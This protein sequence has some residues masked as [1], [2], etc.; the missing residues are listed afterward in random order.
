MSCARQDPRGIRHSAEKNHFPLSA[1]PWIRLVVICLLTVG[2]AGAQTPYVSAVTNSASLS[3]VVSPGAL[4]SIFGTGLGSSASDTAVVVGG[5]AAVVLFV[6]E[7]R[8]NAQL[9]LELE[10]GVAELS[11][12]SHGMPSA[13][14]K[15][16]V[17]R[18]APALFSVD[19]SGSGQGVFTD[20]GGRLI[21]AGVLPGSIVEAY[22]VG[23]GETTPSAAPVSQQGAPVMR[24]VKLPAVHLGVTRAEV[25]SAILTNGSSGVY[26]VEFVVPA[27]L[28]GNWNVTVSMEGITSSPVTLQVATTEFVSSLRAP[29]SLGKASSGSS[30]STSTEVSGSFTRRTGQAL[31]VTGRGTER[32]VNSELGTTSPIADAA[33]GAVTVAGG[34]GVQFT[35]DATLSASLCG[36]VQTVVGGLYARTFT[37]ANANIYI[38]LGNTGLAQS[39]TSLFAVTYN[40]FRNALIASATSSNDRTAVGTL[41]NSNPLGTRQ[42][43]LTN[44]NARV[45]GF[46]PQAGLKPDGTSCFLSAVG[47]YDGIVTLSTSLNSGGQFYFRTGPAIASSQ[48]DFF[49]SIEHEVDEVLGTSSCAFD[50]ANFSRFHPPDLFRYHSDGSRSFAEG[51]NSSCSGARSTN[52]CFSI[53]GVHMLQQYNNVNDGTDAGDWVRNCSSYLVQ[54]AV[55][56]PDVG[57]VDISASAEIVVLDVI[58]YTLTGLAPLTTPTAVFRDASGVIQLSSYPASTLFSSG[59]SF[60]SDPSAAQ[61]ANGDTF[62]AARD[63]FNSIWA[64]VFNSS[65]LTWSGWRFGAGLSQGVPAI[66]VDTS[67]TAWIASRD[68]FNSYWLLN[69]T[70]AKGFSSWTPLLGIFSTDPVLTACG[71]GSIYLIGKDT[72]NSLWSGHYIPGT[73]F[74]GWQYGGGIVKGKPSATCGLDNAVYI[75]A[76]DNFNSNWMARVS[77]NTWN[78][79]FYG[80]ALTSISPRIASLRNG[81]EAVVILDSTNVVW[82]ATYT[83]GTGNGW[84]PWVQVAGIL[85]DVAA[86]GANGQLYLAG[87]TSNGDLWWWQQ[88]GSLWTSFG[89]IGTGAG[90]LAATPK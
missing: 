81:S 30:I 33:R 20:R 74:Q 13:P 4:V 68:S 65:T 42:A 75:A 43:L 73:G 32:L 64:N 77:G 67:G 16:V 29:A 2:C 60:A 70:P 3:P 12:A 6:S 44:A 35:C 58:G 15:I 78:Q 87:R 50:C 19:G 54:D 25:R 82:R 53:D 63:N 56:C 38:T 51:D 90:A 41:P 21:T 37:N 57:F 61:S 69:F 83:E 66:A 14:V 10:P 24:C 55:G 7:T 34:G 85:Q 18:Y 5:H 28:P 9:P 71:D 79:W 89:S 72:F 39:L 8:I 80:G 59:S 26:Q 23:L 48:Y 17:S 22:L 27:V 88:A 45:L 40:S 84:Q 52:A 11:V 47:C 1:M 46:T 36:S 62:V 76:Q 86:A 49:S 31:A